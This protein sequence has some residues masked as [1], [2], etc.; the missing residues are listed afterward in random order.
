MV[1]QVLD[2]CDR[3]IS[4]AQIESSNGRKTTTNEERIAKVRFGSVGVHSVTVVA[5]NHM[6]NNFIVTMPTDNGMSKTLRLSDTVEFTGITF[7]SANLY[8]FYS[9]ICS[10]AMVTGWNSMII[11]RDSGQNGKLALRSK[12]IHDYVKKISKTT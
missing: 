5:D 3:L 6:P 9:I 1:V 4:G 7:G 10:A 12:A 2:Q 11:K 8:P